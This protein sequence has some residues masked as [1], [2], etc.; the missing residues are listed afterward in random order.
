MI[1]LDELERLQKLAEPLPWKEDLYL[2]SDGDSVDA[3]SNID[4]DMIVHTDES[5]LAEAFNCAYIASACNAAPELIAENRELRECMRKL[6]KQNSFFLKALK[7]NFMCP[8]SRC[9]YDDGL[10]PNEWECDAE[11]NRE[12]WI[13]AAKE[14]GE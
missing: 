12:C 1:D 13:Q 14:A 10:E 11:N 2:T 6:D 3:V 9:K 8:Y 5:L 4:G 7:E